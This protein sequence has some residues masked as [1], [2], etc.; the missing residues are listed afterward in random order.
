MKTG[1]LC[2]VGSGS[3]SGV[4]VWSGE[5]SGEPTGKRSGETVPNSN[6]FYIPCKTLAREMS[7]RGFGGN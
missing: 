2:G 4:K 7:T 5:W 6:F 3:D 1:V